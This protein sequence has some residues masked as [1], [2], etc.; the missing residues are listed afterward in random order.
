MD[1]RTNRAR[2]RSLWRRFSKS[3]KVCIAVAV[4]LIILALLSSY[5]IKLWFDPMAAS[6]ITI[7]VVV[8]FVGGIAIDMVVFGILTFAQVDET[9]VEAKMMFS[10]AEQTLEEAQSVL[11]VTRQVSNRSNEVLDSA[12]LAQE[13][14]IVGDEFDDE[15]DNIYD[16]VPD[17]LAPSERQATLLNLPEGMSYEEYMQILQ[18]WQEEQRQKQNQGEQPDDEFTIEEV[19]NIVEEAMHRVSGR[20]SKKPKAEPKDT[21]EDAVQSDLERTQELEKISRSQI[22]LGNGN[23][24][25]IVVGQDTKEINTKQIEAELSKQPNSPELQPEEQ[26][27]PQPQS[28]EEQVAELGLPDTTV[29]LLAY[30]LKTGGYNHYS[31]LP[32]KQRKQLDACKRLSHVG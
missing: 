9:Y 4:V 27:E 22:G 7:L 31:E 1:N 18:D 20:P 6:Q 2:Q 19:Q 12:R 32:P 3:S 11:K 21:D 5:A 10:K 16:I 8:V 28:I 24:I 25:P 15:F 29:S 23:V 30:L 26:L 13:G 14:F 17:G